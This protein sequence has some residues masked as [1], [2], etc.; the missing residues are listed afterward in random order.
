MQVI[1]PRLIAANPQPLVGEGVFLACPIWPADIADARRTICIDCSE[2]DGRVFAVLAPAYIERTDILEL[3]NLPRNL[4]YD[5][6]AG[7]YADRLAPG[8]QC[9]LADG[10]T[11][12]LLLEDSAPPASVPLHIALLG[13]QH[14]GRQPRFPEPTSHGVCCAVFGQDNIL[15]INTRGSPTA[16]RAQI[17]SAVGVQQR[18]LRIL[19]SQPRI[20]DAALEGRACRSVVIIYDESRRP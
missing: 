15:H 18:T 9:H 13:R 16:F 4:D 20:W 17:A 11:F 10:D 6:Y 5:V 12:F 8:S 1:F 3:A 19:S 14:W 2:I 7:P